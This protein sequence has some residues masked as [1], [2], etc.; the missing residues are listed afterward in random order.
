MT[1]TDTKLDKEQTKM[2]KAAAPTLLDAVPS[3]YKVQW[4]LFR[5]EKRLGSGSFGDCFKASTKDGQ[6]VAVKKMRAGECDGCNAQCTVI[7][8]FDR[9]S[10]RRAYR[11]PTPPAGLID[12]TG[13]NAFCKEVNMLA[14]VTHENIVSL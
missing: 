10:K 8:V 4:R 9:K 12:K 14:K 7:L 11:K 6:S 2:V 5:F 13:F 3:M 1:V